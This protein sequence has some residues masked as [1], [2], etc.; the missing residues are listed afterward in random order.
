MARGTEGYRSPELLRNREF[1]NKVDIW[2]MG[3]ILH[4]L[5]TQRRLFISDYDV[6]QY[7]VRSNQL[8]VNLDEGFDWHDRA[9]LSDVVVR[10]LQKEPYQRPSA[11]VLHDEF[12]NLLVMKA[13]SGLGEG[14][15][16]MKVDLARN[17]TSRP[18]GKPD[19]LRY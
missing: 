18:K 8:T 5:A 4:E 16:G 13:K 7:Y 12:V 10:M 11:S 1:N 2:S 19:F 15:E 6:L 14:G 9:A 3:C 17:R